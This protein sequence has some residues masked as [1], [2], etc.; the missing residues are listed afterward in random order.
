MSRNNARSTDGPA[1]TRKFA[2]AAVRAAVRVRNK[3][4]RR[5]REGA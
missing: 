3:L 2:K 5:Q 4:A 1:V